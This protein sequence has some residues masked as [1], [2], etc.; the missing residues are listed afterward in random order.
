MD[1]ALL[2][3]VAVGGAVGGVA[4]FAMAALVDRWLGD[5]L[6]WGTLTINVTGSFALGWLAAWLDPTNGLAAAA[7]ATGV[8][9]SFTTVSALALQVEVLREER[10]WLRLLAYLGLTLGLGLGAVALG[11]TVGGR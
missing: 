10:A 8:L 11:L 7:F 1:P 6:P 3:A 4:R 9:G 5:G 2:A